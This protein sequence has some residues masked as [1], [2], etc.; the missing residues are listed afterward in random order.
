MKDDYDV[1]RG[2]IDRREREEIKKN[3]SDRNESVSERYGFSRDRMSVKGTCMGIE[4]RDRASLVA[5]L[6]RALH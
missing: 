6:V 1:Q 5:Q 2:I 3:W 4:I